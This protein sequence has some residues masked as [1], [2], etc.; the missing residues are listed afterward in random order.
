MKGKGNKLKEKDL[1]KRQKLFNLWTKIL[2]NEVLNTRV[3]GPF[4]I[5]TLEVKDFV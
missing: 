4:P 1:M 2:V 5:L 3:V